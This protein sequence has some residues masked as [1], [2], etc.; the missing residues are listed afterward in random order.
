LIAQLSGNAAQTALMADLTVTLCN[1]VAAYNGTEPPEFT[2][3]EQEEG[4]QQSLLLRFGLF[5]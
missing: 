1:L 5:L 3:G 4:T 2:K